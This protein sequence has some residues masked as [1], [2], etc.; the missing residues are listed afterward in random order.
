MDFTR[1][2]VDRQAFD[3]EVREV[4]RELAGDVIRISYDLDHDSTGDPAVHFRIVL[5]DDAFQQ[6]RLFTATQDVSDAIEYKL[7]PIGRWGVNPYFRY[8]S[9]TTYETSPEP[10]WG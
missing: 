3:A 9:K 5:P 4:E 2:F 10:A 1:A 6:D 8:R 7:Q